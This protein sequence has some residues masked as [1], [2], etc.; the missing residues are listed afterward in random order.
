MHLASL[1]GSKF[2]LDTIPQIQRNF[3]AIPAM[4]FKASAAQQDVVIQ[5]YQFVT[6]YTAPYVHTVL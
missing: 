3:L 4:H 5:Y 1:L 2:T 6:F